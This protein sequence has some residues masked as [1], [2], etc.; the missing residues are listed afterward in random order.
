MDAFYRRSEASF[1]SL[2]R[3]ETLPSPAAPSTAS[4]ASPR[5]VDSS[6]HSSVQ[7]MWLPS[8]SPTFRAGTLGDIDDE[9]RGE[10]QERR[11]RACGPSSSSDD[12][13]EDEDG[14]EDDEEDLFAGH[15]GR[16]AGRDH[17]HDD[18]DDYDAR[19]GMR[20]SLAFCSQLDREQERDEA[21]V[22]SLQFDNEPC[23]RS[24]CDY[25]RVPPRSA[26]KGSRNRESSRDGNMLEK[27]V[28]FDLP[29]LPKPYVPPH[30][31]QGQP[32]STGT[33]PDHVL[34]PERYTVY[35]FDDDDDDI[36]DITTNNRM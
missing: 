3:A 33:V 35:T 14:S 6:S 13:S 36:D 8:R 17:D 2:G 20:A 22:A 11:R 16:R 9:M 26:L 15:E 10:D 27:R 34:H 30:K 5:H 23:Y 19:I 28:S 7:D 24:T 29:D 4:A 1:G 25:S 18:D 21:D 31:R 32:T 12:D